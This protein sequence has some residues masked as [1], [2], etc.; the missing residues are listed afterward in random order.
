MNFDQ[1]LAEVLKSEGGY[2][3]HPED[4]GGET[5]HGITARVARLNGYEGPMQSIPMDLV[6]AIYRNDYWSK[7]RCDDLPEQ[8]RMPVFD[9][10]VNSG[11]TQ[12]IKWLQR[13]SGADADGVFGS[14]TLL[15][16]RM[17]NPEILK[18]KFLAQRLNFMTD[19]KVWP[20][21]GRGWAKRIASLME[22]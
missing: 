6:K 12:A 7:C 11:V 1:A 17:Q 15:A 5:N 2:V 22:G 19:L 13:A 18:R 21:F 4:P 14:K 20:V 3:N 16:V 9:A 10:A 8:L